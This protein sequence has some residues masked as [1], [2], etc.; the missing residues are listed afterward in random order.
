[1]PEEKK[2]FLVKYEEA[3]LSPYGKYPGSR[4]AEELLHNGIVVIDKPVGPTSQT[5]DVWIK[6]I[7]G[8]NKCSHGGTLD[9]RVSGVLVIALENAVKLMPILLKSRKEYV[10][11]MHIHKDLPAEKVASVLKKFVGKI[12]QVPPK[13]SA[14]ARRERE[15]QIYSL[16]ILEISGRNI[17]MRVGCE[18][19]TYIR[20]LCDDIGKKLGGAHMQELRRTKAGVF[21]EDMA[22]KLQD[23]KDAYEFWKSGNEEYLR[24]IIYPAERAADN[25]KNVIIKDSAIAAVC[26][27][28]PLAVGGLLRIQKN[29]EPSELVGMLSL[30]GEL[31]AIGIAQM[32][33]EQ[34]L[35]NKKGIAVK[36]DRVFMKKGAYPEWKKS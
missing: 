23:L 13:K 19:G 12:K 21:T 8:I 29:I 32:T 3:S 36:T 15:R 17:L 28:A 10:A 9:P 24:N 30:K 34:M 5:V 25:M 7:L 6:K 2:Q 20:K 14:V 11:I 31:A 27:G 26:N 1:M 33:S 16:D 35:K 4:S 18:A 22:I